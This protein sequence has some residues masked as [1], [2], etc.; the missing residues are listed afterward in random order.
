M[1]NILFLE[2]PAGVGFSYSNT[3]SDYDHSGDSQTAEYNYTFL[4]NWQER[5]PEN[6]N[7]D[8]FKT[9]ESYAGHYI[10]QFAQK[11]LQNNKNTNH[12][13]IK[14][15]GIAVS[16]PNLASVLQFANT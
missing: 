7:R 3:T 9:G 5:F 12:T 10:P 6:E 14:L 2:S 11:I 4:I 8:F 1:A 13:V 16:C 15:Q